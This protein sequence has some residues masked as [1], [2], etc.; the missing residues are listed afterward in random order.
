[1]QGLGDP[2]VRV[3]GDVWN[4]RDN[5][6]ALEHHHT[7][8]RVS[9][10]SL[11]IKEKLSGLSFITTEYFLVSS[12]CYFQIVSFK[13]IFLNYIKISFP[14]VFHFKYAVEFSSFAL[15]SHYY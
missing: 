15:Q 14:P 5:P 8:N 1:M 3:G 7:A 11:L 4:T 9:A 10:S 2:S 13:R 6:T 12:Q